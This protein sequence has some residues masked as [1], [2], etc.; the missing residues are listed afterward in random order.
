MIPAARRICR[1]TAAN[2]IIDASAAATATISHSA[3]DRARSAT[4]DS[5]VGPAST[6]SV[7]SIATTSP[8]STSLAVRAQPRRRPVPPPAGR[9]GMGSMPIAGAVLLIGEPPGWP[10]ILIIGGHS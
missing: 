1:R 8:P 5:M 3:E 10:V 7:V 9:S 6:N 2:A 4:A